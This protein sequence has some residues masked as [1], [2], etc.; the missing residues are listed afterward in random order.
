MEKLR[1]IVTAVTGHRAFFPA[2]VAV[3]ALTLGILFAFEHSRNLLKVRGPYLVVLGAILVFPIFAFRFF[4]PHEN[5][6]PIGWYFILVGVYY[7][8]LGSPDF[9]AF[10]RMLIFERMP[11]GTIKQLAFGVV[12]FGALGGGIHY[13][14]KLFS[15]SEQPAGRFL[16]VSFVKFLVYAVL[17]V[18]YL[19]LFIAIAREKFGILTVFS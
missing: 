2:L 7:V 12:A 11:P 17:H 19:N 6:R 4:D 10:L 9:V 5:P 18:V 1:G 15:T 16:A 14:M 13:M 8:L 3:V